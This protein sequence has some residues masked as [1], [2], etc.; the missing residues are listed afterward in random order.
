MNTSSKTKQLS[1]LLEII[2]A[3]AHTG[4]AFSTDAYDVIRY[5][6]ILVALGKM[7]TLLSDDDQST[8]NIIS[9]LKNTDVTIGDKEYVTPKVAVATVIFNHDNEVLLVKRSKNLWSLPGGYADIGLCPSENA[10]KEVKEETGIEVKVSSLLG[11]YDSNINNFPN[12]GRQT[13]TLVFYAILLGGNINADPLETRG[14]SFFKLSSLPPIP[15]VTYSQIE[16]AVRIS[17]GEPLQ[18]FIDL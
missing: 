5:K 7:S 9:Y 11:V 12:I 13:Y 1:I 8:V 3:K 2:S 17:Q 10:E 18:A 14:A 15:S 16:R 6:E 4:L